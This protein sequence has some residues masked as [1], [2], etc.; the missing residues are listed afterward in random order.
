MESYS[1]TVRWTG[2]LGEGTREYRGYS[3]A[4]VL[5][6]PDKPPILASSGMGARVDPHRVN[7]EEL[8]VGALAS[9]HMLWYLH[10]CAE[11]GV[12][13]V[14]YSDRASGELELSAD[15]TG[16]FARATLRPRVVVATGDPDIA[17]RLHVEAHRRCFIASSVNFPVGIEPTIET[18]T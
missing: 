11:A 15:G 16:R 3:R 17:A 4:H 5:E 14:E 2:N 10:L 18:T 8:L 13:V 7:P 9:C 12:V 6:F 1:V